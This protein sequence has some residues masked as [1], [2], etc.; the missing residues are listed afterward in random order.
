MEQHTTTEAATQTAAPEHFRAGIEDIVIL[1]LVAIALAMVKLTKA[2]FTLLI[3]LIDFMFPILLQL[4]RFPLFTLRILG[5]GIAALTS[6]M[7]AILPVGSMR[8]LAWRKAIG[9][10]WDW[11]RQKFSYR[12][13]EEWIHHTFEKGMA[14]VFRRCRTLKPQTALLVI[15]A[16]LLWLPISFGAA[17]LLHAV[18][19]AKATTWPAWVQFLHPLATIIAKSKLLVLPVYPAAWPQA[20]KNS[21]VQ[22]MLKSYQ[23]FKLLYF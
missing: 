7:V 5:D 18:L 1:P 12:V 21:S 10:Y 19:I 9:M 23:S 22:L 13:F 6:A 4:M 17:T 8:R 11:L 15:F 20:K 2:F 14:W 3:R 16:A